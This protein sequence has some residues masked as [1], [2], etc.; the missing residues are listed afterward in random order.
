MKKGQVENGKEKAKKIKNKKQK[1]NRKRKRKV[2]SRKVEVGAEGALMEGCRKR[3]TEIYSVK[4]DGRRWKIADW[5]K[6]ILPA[7]VNNKKKKG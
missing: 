2:G 6:P 1:E 7:A 4:K 3:K 5:F